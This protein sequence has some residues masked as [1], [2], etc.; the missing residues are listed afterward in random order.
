MTC[1]ICFQSFV[2]AQLKLSEPSPRG[3]RSIGHLAQKSPSATACQQHSTQSTDS[4][5]FSLFVPFF[6]TCLISFGFFFLNPTPSSR[7]EIQPLG[8][9]QPTHSPRRR[10]EERKSTITRRKAKEKKTRFVYI[11]YSLSYIRS[12]CLPFSSLTNSNSPLTLSSFAISHKLMISK[13][14][15][16]GISGGG[17]SAA[18]A[19]RA[20]SHSS[21]VSSSSSDSD[22]SSGESEEHR[23]MKER[24]HRHRTL[25]RTKQDTDATSS[26]EEH[27]QSTR[28]HQS[29]ASG[30]ASSAVPRRSPFP[31]PSSSDSDS[32]PLDPTNSKSVSVMHHVGGPKAN[33]FITATTSVP[34]DES[35]SH[36]T[37][38]PLLAEDEALQIILDSNGITREEHARNPQSTKHAYLEI[39]QINRY[40]RLQGFTSFGPV[41]RHLEIMQQNLTMI[42]G[43]QALVNLEILYLNNNSIRRI[44]GL[45]SN[46][47]LQE[48]YLGENMIPRI[49]GLN[50]LSQL[51]VLSLYDNQIARIEGLEETKQLKKLNLA[52]NK[53]EE[54]NKSAKEKQEESHSHRNP[55][56]SFDLFHL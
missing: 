31:D 42:E 18:S 10:G 39:F 15:S 28:V 23:R 50:H 33:P 22:S 30:A 53:V 29:S 12:N 2:D 38:F 13:K 51:T 8:T 16:S 48:L 47:K 20:R 1:C 46:T 49:E 17:F 52:R 40:R 45:D 34:P 7:F 19:L 25:N 9:I 11:I 32:D 37:P 14:S 55:S 36:H 5:L 21:V 56:S 26:D 54:I 27:Q 35:V 24:R 41:V 4:M 43:L 6:L 44:S 3:L